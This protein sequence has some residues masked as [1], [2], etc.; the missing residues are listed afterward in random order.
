MLWWMQQ[1]SATPLFQASWGAMSSR[2]DPIIINTRSQV[3]F[4][5]PGARYA[6]ANRSDHLHSHFFNEMAPPMVLS[7]YQHRNHRIGLKMPEKATVGTKPGYL[8]HWLADHGVMSSYW[9]EFTME[10]NRLTG[11]LEGVSAMMAMAS[12]VNDM[13][14]LPYGA[15]QREIDEAWMV[16]AH[17]ILFR[18]DRACHHADLS[19][20]AVEDPRELQQAKL[21]VQSVTSMTARSASA[22]RDFSRERDFFRDPRPFKRAREGDGRAGGFSRDHRPFSFCEHHRRKVRHTTAE[23]NLNP[24]R[25]SQS[26]GK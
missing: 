21:R 17:R 5:G 2:D 1:Q 15:T 25:S 24:A 20:L 11:D 18:L 7:G 16:A 19:Y 23:C 9:G 4:G 3:A 26:A 13:M 10:V 8:F 6:A 12:A 22:Y 14:A